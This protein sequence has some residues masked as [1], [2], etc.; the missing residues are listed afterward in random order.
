M[1]VLA[2]DVVLLVK[3]YSLILNSLS[4]VVFFII[5]TTARAL[6]SEDYIQ[7]PSVTWHEF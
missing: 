7:I 5:E 4:T 1:V 6:V 2:A 3:C